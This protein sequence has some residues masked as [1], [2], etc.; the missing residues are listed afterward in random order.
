VG[1]TLDY[2]YLSARFE[3]IVNNVWKYLVVKYFT[4]DAIKMILL[5]VGMTIR[6]DRV[7]LK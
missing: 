2:Y 7:F 4:K 5:P 6:D 1:I 3:D